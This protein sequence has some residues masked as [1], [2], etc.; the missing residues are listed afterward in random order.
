[1]EEHPLG[2]YQYDYPES[3]GSRLRGL[4]KR[5]SDN[6][7]EKWDHE[8]N[9]NPYCEEATTRGASINV[10]NLLQSKGGA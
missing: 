10:A 4:A 3:L 7:L 9:N 5:L 2:S 6:Y 1:M 8:D